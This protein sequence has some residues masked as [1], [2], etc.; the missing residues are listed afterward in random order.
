MLRKPGFCRV[1]E[2]LEFLRFPLYSPHTLHKDSI[3][4]PLTPDTIHFFQA[5]NT[6]HSALRAQNKD[7]EWPTCTTMQSCSVMLH[8][9]T[10]RY[11]P[12]IP[13]SSGHCCIFQKLGLA[14]LQKSLSLPLRKWFRLEAPESGDHVM[15][16]TL[17]ALEGFI[18]GR[19]SSV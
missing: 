8:I 11:A 5:W 9:H 10:H 12:G 2:T 15:W 16:R 17:T 3:E 1:K 14:V 4:S 18:S 7:R 13:A 6:Q 19:I